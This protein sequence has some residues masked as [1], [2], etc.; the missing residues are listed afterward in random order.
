MMAATSSSCYKLMGTMPMPKGE[1]PFENIIKRKRK[2]LPIFRVK[3]D[4][5]YLFDTCL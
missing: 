5:F 1:S 2:K 4:L 3:L